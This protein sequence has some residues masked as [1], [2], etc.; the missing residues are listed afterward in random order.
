[1]EENFL[2]VKRMYP[3]ERANPI[4]KDLY[5]IHMFKLMRRKT[6]AYA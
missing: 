2:K 3:R 6:E 5:R 4:I 1:M